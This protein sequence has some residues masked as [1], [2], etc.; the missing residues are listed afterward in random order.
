MVDKYLEK[1]SW[2]IDILPKQVPANS[3]GQYFK[4]E[5]YFLA[6]PQYEIICIKFANILLKLNCY[7]DI[8]VCHNLEERILNPSPELLINWIR[9]R[10]LLYVLLKSSDALIGITG[11]DHYMTLYNP[12]E[13]LIELIRSLAAAEGLYMWKPTTNNQ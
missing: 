12:D 11:D 5:K 1:E 6:Q 7:D 9:E 10:K 8:E 2:V 13:E 4:I 3:S